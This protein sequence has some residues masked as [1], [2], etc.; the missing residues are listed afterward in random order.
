M[1]IATCFRSMRSYGKDEIKTERI[2]FVIL[3][4]EFLK[5]SLSGSLKSV[6]LLFFSV[7]FST[8]NTSSANRMHVSL[9]PNKMQWSKWYFCLF[10]EC[11]FFHRFFES[12]EERE[13]KWQQLQTFMTFLIN[14]CWLTHAV[15]KMIN[16]YICCAM[17]CH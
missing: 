14:L 2:D 15:F 4:T 12:R 11:F 5:W 1:F 13:L 10:F 9:K 7:L 8:M 17:A 6:C 3:L 16:R